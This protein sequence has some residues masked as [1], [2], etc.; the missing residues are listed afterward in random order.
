MKDRF[1]KVFNNE[2]GSPTV[3]TLIAIA[4]SLFVIAILVVFGAILL[5]YIGASTSSVVSL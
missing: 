3:E 4:V 2:N 5:R 1:L